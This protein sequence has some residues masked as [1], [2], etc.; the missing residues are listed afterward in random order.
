[1]SELLDNAFRGVNIIPTFLL[2]FVLFYWL[3]VII[4]V[5]DFDL[6]D[7]D[8]DGGADIG[9]FHAFLAFLNL[10]ELPFMLVFSVI[11]LVFWILAMFM[12]LLPITPGGLT[13]G[14][15][16]IPAFI[17]SSLI[18][19][20]ITNPLKKIF[21]KVYQEELN[22]GEPIVGQI[23]T[24]MCDLKDG[25]LG[26]GEIKREGASILINVK[27]Y[28]ENETFIKGEEAYVTKKNDE[29]NVYYIIKI[30]E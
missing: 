2:G 28:D 26:Q 15:L 17:V 10:S 25:R 24:L 13:N 3:T 18:A 12:F 23:V 9:P 7:F 29:K 20:I 30:K 22:Q 11:V 16:L 27:Q 5:I 8:I 4:G 14:L 1:M 19:K 21:K 6:F